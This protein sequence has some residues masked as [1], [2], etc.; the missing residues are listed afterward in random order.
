[1]KRFTII[2]LSLVTA[3]MAA[4]AQPMLK[5]T[6]F[7]SGDVMQHSRVS[8]YLQDSKGLMWFGTWI[9]LC[10]YDGSQFH[11]F[12]PE[13]TDSV[14]RPL[15]SNRVLKMSLDRLD[16]IWCLN[17][18]QGVYRFDRT[19]STYQAVLPL[20]QGHEGQMAQRERIYVCPRNH[21]VWVVL[22][23]G[24]LVRYNDTDL[25]DNETLP[26]PSGKATREVYD[27]REDSHGCEWILTDH[28][29]IRYGQGQITNVPYSR[30]VER[31]GRCFFT[32]S[33]A[34]Q[35]V[36]YTRTGK[37]RELPLPDGVSEVIF[38]QAI[39]KNRLV[40]GTDC[41][42]EVYNVAI[43]QM[44]HIECRLPDGSL[45]RIQ[46]AMTDSQGRVWLLGQKRGIHCW[47]SDDA[48][49][50]YLPEPLVTNPRLTDP[51]HL[52]L[53]M[54][55]AY[56]TIWTKPVGGELCWV[57]DATLT[58]H[59]HSECI[60]DGQALPVT[61]YNCLF[62]DRQKNLW[63][64]NGTKVCQVVFGPRQFQSLRA[65]AN[66]EVRALL[67]DDD[68]HVL[69]G[70]KVGH[71]CRYDIATG[72]VQYLSPQGQW[73]AQRMVFNSD[74]IY[75]LFRDRSQRVWVGTRGSGIYCLTA[76]G[77]NYHIEHYRQRLGRY[78][79]NCDNI[80]DFCQD[81]HGRIWV[82]T[83]GGGINLMQPQPDGSM[84]FLHAANDMRQYPI[85]ECDVVRSLQADGRGRI[86]AGTNQGVLAFTSV[87]DRVQDI[88]FYRHESLSQQAY[89]L[90]DN[91]V[92]RILCDSVGTYYVSTY[93]R[94]LSRVE[95][96]GLDS[97]RFVPLP[98]RAY[99]AG[100]VA[101]TAYISSRGHVWSI[102]ECGITD[103]NPA[104][105]RMWYFD[106]HDFPRPYVLSE[107]AP[108]EMPDGRLVLGRVGG[109]VIFQ[110][111]SLSKSSYSPRI[112]LTQCRYARGAVGY[113]LDINDI[114]TLE[115]QPY[116]RSAMLRFAVLD[117][118][119]S[120]MVRYAYWMQ[121][122]S[123]DADAPQW[124]YTETPTVNFT[125]LPHGT[126]ILHLRSTNS[127]GVWCDNDRQL[128]IIAVPTAWERW[129]WLIIGI[130]VAILAVSALLWYVRRLRQQQEEVVRHEV[131]AA[132]IEM[133]SSPTNRADQEFIQRLMQVLESHLSNGELQV[134]DLADEMN[135]SRATLYRRLKQA[136]DLSPN[137]FIHQVR[138]RRS[139]EM[140]VQ[141]SDTIAQIA[142][143]VGFN[144]PKYF[145]KCFR[146]DYGISPAEYR[147]KNKIT[148]S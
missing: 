50:R 33:S 60:P 67:T 91:M 96:E 34:A 119:P 120:R 7:T 123:D 44:Q 100:D 49:P 80:Y 51:G 15:G 113:Q 142:Y 2:L 70:D 68:T 141:S 135:M 106:R 104:D 79:L 16:N 17:N 9:G 136:V 75:C 36:E 101:M 3:V 121:A 43:D 138:M 127:D 114:D 72:S 5:Y 99:P 89:P 35:V 11:F 77:A 39:D 88:V 53:L 130:I 26:C 47:A 10:R 57:D 87:F 69:Y 90:Q 48:Q 40:V 102:A 46:R 37:W 98:N 29:V 27:V 105:G 133:L 128:T 24:T 131:S 71:L 59:H 97:L 103:Y 55:D 18:D 132:R 129:G 145:S 144:N 54:Q 28:G 93:A 6:E 107:C 21:V 22:D 32:S 112:V 147:A 61:E 1:M 52:M 45:D 30:I 64:S 25:T 143:S 19:T 140:L 20:V 126:Y 122:E 8:S 66:V 118:V 109:M 125:N 31:L 108:T 63:I 116:Q 92:M 110:P 13:L 139:A 146:Q 74:G 12:H 65:M 111:D 134:N 117:L 95:G 86:L 58:L 41:G 42:V 78:E 56:G 14:A 115:L 81:E 94:G 82:A 76:R 62:V 73:T 83:F 148:E 85:E 23:D 38:M 84:R 137:D 4:T 124:V